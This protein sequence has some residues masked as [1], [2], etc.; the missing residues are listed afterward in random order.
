MMQCED[1]TSL[2]AH[3]ERLARDLEE[4]RDRSDVDG[5]AGLLLLVL[6]A[7]LVACSKCALHLAPLQ[8]LWTR[9][10]SSC[11]HCSTVQRNKVL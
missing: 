6:I 10:E 9:K 7:D 5:L 11:A 1:A 2:Q 8:L 4:F 3:F